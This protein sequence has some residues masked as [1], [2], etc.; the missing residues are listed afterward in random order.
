[1]SLSFQDL[2]LTLHRY[3]G[4][5]GC[6]LLQPYDMEMGA[7][8]FHPATVLRALG[9]DLLDASFD[10]L[11]WDSMRAEDAT[12]DVHV[13]DGSLASV[14]APGRPL[15]HV[16]DLRLRASL[17]EADWANEQIRAGVSGYVLSSRARDS[18]TD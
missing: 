5:K 17:H 6:V 15:A 18:S 10:P 3:W 8:T 9:P 12:V 2:I 7:G 16:R 4:A 13:L 11:Y 14:R 1:M